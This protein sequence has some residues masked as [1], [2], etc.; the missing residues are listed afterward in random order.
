MKQYC[1]FPRDDEHPKPHSG[2]SEVYRKESVNLSRRQP[3]PARRLI[4]SRTAPNLALAAIRNQFG[5]TD[6]Q[7]STNFSGSSGEKPMALKIPDVF[8]SKTWG[9]KSILIPHRSLKSILGVLPK[10]L[11]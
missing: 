3:F 1:I 4:Q 2:V 6:L 5:K 7:I 10:S 9:Q 11:R 8:L